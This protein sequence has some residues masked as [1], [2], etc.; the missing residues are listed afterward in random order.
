MAFSIPTINSFRRV[1]LASGSL[2]SLD[3]IAVSGFTE[4]EMK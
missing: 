1:K 2:V 3:V 4:T